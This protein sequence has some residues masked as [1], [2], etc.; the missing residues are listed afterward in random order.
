MGLVKLTVFVVCDMNV[1]DTI[2]K[3]VSRNAARSISSTDSGNIIFHNIF[4]MN[5]YG[6][7]YDVRLIPISIKR[8]ETGSQ[9]IRHACFSYRIFHCPV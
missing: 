2:A 6:F 1:G 8:L 7:G 4:Y 5:H 3:I 9:I